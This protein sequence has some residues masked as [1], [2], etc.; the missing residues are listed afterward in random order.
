LEKLKDDLPNLKY[1]LM[2]NGPEMKP[3]KQ[4]AEKLG[5]ADRIV[6][7]GWLPTETELNNALASADIGLVMRIGQATDHFHMTDTLA[8][9]MACGKPILAVNLRGIA[10]VIHNGENGFLFSPDSP[11]EFCS[12]LKQLEE[13]STLR[14]DFG[15]K[16]DWESKKVADTHT[17]AQAVFDRIIS[18]KDSPTLAL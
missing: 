1:L 18:S 6:F 7:A 17:A 14:K 5:L 15:E 16:A 4:L 2:G 9:E 10:E 8:H 3:L 13:S 12:K 11:L